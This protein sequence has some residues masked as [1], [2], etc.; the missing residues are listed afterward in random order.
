MLAPAEL[1]S[2]LDESLRRELVTPEAVLRHVMPKL[3]GTRILRL[4]AADRAGHGVPESAL[5]TLALR[6]IR[7]YRLPEPVRQ[8]ELLAKGRRVRFDL[9][10]PDHRVAIELDGRAPHWG[11]DRWQADH[12]RHNAVELSGWRSLRFTWWDI[13]ERPLDV[14][15]RIADALGLRPVRWRSDAARRPSRPGR[16]RPRGP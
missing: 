2:A 3:R 8:L 1:E 5:E 13:T 15:L 12:D 14:A 9:A 16:S 4:L 11:R 6:L 7:R 10:Y